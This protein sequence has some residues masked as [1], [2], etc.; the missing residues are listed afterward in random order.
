[1]SFSVA[2]LEV[3]QATRCFVYLDLQKANF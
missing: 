1:M 3:V 2:G